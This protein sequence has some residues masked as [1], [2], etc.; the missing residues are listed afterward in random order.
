MKRKFLRTHTKINRIF[1]E[2]CLNTMARMPDNFIDLVITSPPYDKLRDYKGYKFDFKKIAKELFRVVK[3]GGTVVW[4]IDDA[5]VEGSKTGT[6]FKQALYFMEVG[7]KLHDVMIWDKMALSPGALGNVRYYSAYEFMLIL[8]K[9]KLKT[10][11]PIK[12]R[13]NKHAG[14]SRSITRKLKDGSMRRVKRKVIVATHSQRFN[15]WQS[16]SESGLKGSDHPAPFPQQLI[17]D[18]LI[19]WSNEG[20]L[21]YDPCIGSGT[22]AKACL[23][24]GRYFIGS[25]IS[26]EY[27]RTANKRISGLRNLFN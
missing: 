16:S 10:F 3:E 7:F 5:I 21:I 25:E 27:C 6:S 9:G 2:N 15:I 18:H 23:Y 12:D 1:N 19:S 8:V 11:N 24:T 4:I 20:D 13:L 26:K 22:T 14:E 17:T